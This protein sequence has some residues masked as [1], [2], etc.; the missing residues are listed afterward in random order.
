[1]HRRSVITGFVLLGLLAAAGAGAQTQQP[2]TAG[3]IPVVAHLVGLNG[4]FWT[5]D[6]YV[7]Q[8]AGGAAAQV[9]LTVLNPGGPGWSRDIV[10][11]AANG[12]TVVTDVV[13][14][15]NAAIP[16]GKYVLGWDA[17]QPVVVTSRTFT[18]EGAKTYGQGTGS[19]APGSGFG[20][21]GTVRLPAPM[22]DGGHR[23]NVGVANAG[24]AAQQFTVTALD[25]T[26]AIL[27]SWGL[28]VAPHEVQQLRVN[29]AGSGAGSVTV[30]CTSRCD[31][32]AYAYMSVVVNSSNDASFTYAAA[33]ADGGE[34]APIQTARDTQ[35][36]WYVTGGTLY[37]VFEAM[38]Y[39]V[40]TDRLWQIETYR[41]SSRGTLAEVFGSSQL[42]TD[43]FV[44]TISY[45]EAELVA[46]YDALDGES[47]TM[48]KAYADGINRRI[49]EVRDD[50]SLLP[51]EFKAVGAQ[52]GLL[53]VP[54]D[55]TV[56]DLL[57]WMAMLQRQFDPEALATGQ[58]DS[59]ALMQELAAT[60]PAEYQNMFDDLRWLNDPE[61]QTYVPASGGGMAASVR[62]ALPPVNA[63]SIPDTRAAAR[64]LSSL[65]ATVDEN[66]TRIGAKVKMGSYG[67]TVS[68][69]KTA[70]GRP[71]IYSGPQMGFPV[72]SIVL[73]GSI[74]GGGLV[75]SGMSVPG[76]PGIIIGRTPHHAWAM[77]VGHAHTTD[78]YLDDQSAAQLHRMETIRVA[79][80]ADVTIPVFRTPHGPVVNPMPFVPGQTSGPVVAWKYAHWGYEF[81]IVKAFLDLGRAQSM[82]QFGA[83]I[84]RVAVSQNFPYS[85]RDGN[86]AYWMSGR[87]P[88][89][90][91]G[92][93]PRLPQ[94][95]DGTQEWPQPVRLKPRSTDRNTPVGYYAGW[96]NKSNANYDNSTNNLG[97]AYGPYHGAHV[98]YDYLS[99]H[100]QMTFEELRDL[101]QHVA[102]TDCFALR[103]GI[104]WQ[105]LGPYFA[106]A[107]QSDPNASRTAALAMLDAWDGHFV[108]GGS[109]QWV[110]G[111][112]K[113]D[114]WV[115]AEEWAKEVIKLT[116]EDELGAR[117]TPS[118]TLL[119]VLLHGLKGSGSGIV[120]KVDWFADRSASGKP[121]TANG[122]IVLALDNALARLGAQ[123]WDQARGTIPF[124]HTLIGKVHEMPYAN[125]STY[126]HCIE[127]GPNGPTRIESMFPLG[128]SG[129]ILMSGQG[130]PVFDANFFTM[131]PYFDAFMPRSYPL[132][133]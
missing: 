43:V 21:N 8:S 40:A 59:A 71:I 9:R 4:S 115:L 84:E 122:L 53:F 26:G 112:L 98:L 16:D 114:A 54:A 31:G 5:T 11:P 22:D 85:D 56:T 41:R 123:P 30:R 129:T 63:R 117:A 28:S 105:F 92:A 57:A 83:A 38:G 72:P 107:V 81:D 65:M 37:D 58:L 61:A 103:R 66:L 62:P 45:S 50:S 19:L 91:A 120:N 18:T 125:R 87:D 46:G 131:A 77:Q 13:R 25:A 95:G 82:D 111:T 15:V 75:I 44:R 96:N 67:W 97:Y 100:D 34:V 49:A 70:S 119:N 12:A 93:D 78:Y 76:I 132:F 35:G 113:A 86:I 88:V 33:T 127:Y 17:T 52:L 130:T 51:F 94:R 108:A 14:F 24:G 55:W 124:N 29:E 110:A 101:A 32:N 99:T 121:T 106:A 74:V 39:A 102:T 10:L 36:T 116:F 6:L 109:S 80:G 64:N 128:E 73:E 48:I 7:T 68:G 42:S 3:V 23:V 2:M 104:A 79:G 126:A 47:R 20:T 133:P 60:Y 118:G 1:M 27:H 69:S 90:A 89:R